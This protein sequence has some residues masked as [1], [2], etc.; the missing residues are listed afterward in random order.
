MKFSITRF[1]NPILRQKSRSLSVAEIKREEI[2]ALITDMIKL[3]ENENFGVGLAAPQVGKSLAVA[4]IDIRPT[5]IRPN[6][7]VYRSVIIN[8]M[9]KGIGRRQSL[10]EGCLSSGLGEETLFGKVLRYRKI[11]ASWLDEKAVRHDEE[12]TGLTAQVFQHESDHLDGIL[13][14]DKVRDSHSFMLGDEYRK[15]IER[16]KK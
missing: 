14:V 6:V 4:I 15:M 3:N 11:Y 5:K 12:L 7:G 1:G 10:W 2:Q 13:F 9:Y 16:L 8:P